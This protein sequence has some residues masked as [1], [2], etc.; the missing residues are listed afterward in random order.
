[1]KIGIEK[2]Y[3]FSIQIVTLIRKTKKKKNAYGTLYEI[4]PDNHCSA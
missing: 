2:L 1:M 3:I 4:L